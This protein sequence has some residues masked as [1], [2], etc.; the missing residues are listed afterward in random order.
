MNN[1]QYH[2]NKC[3]DTRIIK[4]KPITILTDY[5]WIPWNERECE[6]IMEK[7]NEKIKNGY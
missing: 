1:P 5:I 4:Y 7:S 2:C 3:K 6:C